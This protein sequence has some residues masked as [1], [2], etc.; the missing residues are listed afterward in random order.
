MSRDEGA[1]RTRAEPGDS[2]PAPFHRRCHG[3]ARLAGLLFLRLGQEFIPTL[4]EKNIAMH[5][6]RIPST[7]LSQSQSMQLRIEETLTKF[8]Q[9][10]LVFSKTGTADMATD[11][12]PPNVS[13]TFIMLKPR[14]EWPDPELTKAELQHQIE[15]AV[16]A[17]AGNAYE[18]TQPIQ[19]RFN[20]LIAGVRGDIAIKVF[21][22]EFG[23]MLRAANQIA[24]IL[25]S[26]K[27]AEDVRVEQATGLPFLKIKIDKAGIARLG[28]SISAVQDAIGAAIGGL[29]AGVVFEGD[30]RF[31]IIVRLN[32]KVRENLEALKHLPVELP[33]SAESGPA[34]AILLE[35]VAKFELSAGQ[36]QISRE[37]GKRRVVVT[38]NV[39][40][41]DIGSLM[42][43]VQEKVAQKVQLPAG[44]WLSWGGQ[45]EN[46]TAA[47]QRLMIVVPGCFFLIFLLLYT[48]LGSPRDALLVFSA[49][50]LAL[51]GGVA[52]LWLRGMPFS[53]S[54]AV[55]F[56]ALSGVAVLNG[57]VML[58]YIKQLIGEGTPFL[59]AIYQ[60]AV[61][62]LRP[63]AMTALVASLGFVPM[64]LATGTGAEVQKP[65]ATVVIGGLIS[66]TLLTLLVLPALYA[67]FGQRKPTSNV[68]TISKEKLH[69]SVATE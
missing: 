53:I 12:M 69:H 18:F 51:T 6:I 16:G 47:R 33:S 30:R 31:P 49:V 7:A 25:R 28:L 65:L 59:P 58:T 45:F 43:E 13:D 40:G 11:P 27:G 61:T 46:L 62:R 35:Q 24:S 37:N 29:E 64:A 15:L 1:L 67:R 56:I 42:A 39:R 54:A 5:A 4:D 32:D 10:A 60:G 20:E 34:P 68:T 19:M 63:V 26:T 57:L 38:A 48:A 14:D 41:R 52:A 22:E 23:P 55:G 44:Y 9:V 17:L 8:P 50:P 3:L 66:A 2:Y 21:G 36:N